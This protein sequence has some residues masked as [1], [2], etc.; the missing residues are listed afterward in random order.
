MRMPAP[1]R[2]WQGEQASAAPALSGSRER[3]PPPL[4]MRHSVQAL[5]PTAADMA[6]DQARI[7]VRRES[8]PPLPSDA[9]Q[10]IESQKKKWFRRSTKGGA[11]GTTPN[12]H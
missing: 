11:A 9:S 1:V 8:L 2:T 7:H 4:R 10:A 3:S 5:S 6:P 12:A